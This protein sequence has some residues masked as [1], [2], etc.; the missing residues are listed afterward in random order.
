[1]GG[2]PRAPPANPSRPPSSPP[3][4]LPPPPDCGAL[5]PMGSLNAASR[6]SAGQLAVCVKQNSGP[7]P[8]ECKPLLTQFLALPVPLDRCPGGL[9]EYTMCLGAAPQLYSKPPPPPS[10]PPAG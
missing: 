3:P 1:M 2:S 9:G 7:A 5:C 10:P 4:P 8:N 6:N